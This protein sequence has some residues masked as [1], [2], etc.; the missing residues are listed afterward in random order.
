MTREFRFYKE[1]DINHYYRRWFIDLPEYP[2]SKDE[3]EMVCGADDMLDIL[4][5]RND[6]VTLEICLEP[7]EDCKE[8]EIRRIIGCEELEHREVCGGEF[9]SF[10]E[11]ELWLCDVTKHVFG[12]FPENIYFKVT[13]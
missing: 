1:Q 8:L 2:G 5:D 13:K 3:L 6:E 10:G 7:F 9:Y 12:Y 4:S 11:L